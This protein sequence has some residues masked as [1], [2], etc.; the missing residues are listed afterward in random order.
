MSIDVISSVHERV[1]GA[2]FELQPGAK[3]APSRLDSEAWL[4]WFRHNRARTSAEV[5]EPVVLPRELHDALVHALQVFQL[6]EAGEGRVAKEAARSADPVLDAALVE[7][8]DLYI[9]EEGRHARELLV[10][11]RAM[12]VEPLRRT[13]AEK[14]FRWTRRAMGL[15][16]KML[17]IAVAEIVGVV[18][19]GL[20]RDR[21]A[22]SALADTAARI[23]ADEAAHL[24]FQAAL[25]RAFLA[26][27]PLPVPRMY[28]AAVAAVFA[29]VLAAAIA[30]VAIDQRAFLRAIG[31]SPT[32]LTRRCVDELRARWPLEDRASTWAAFAKGVGADGTRSAHVD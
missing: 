1:L 26:H 13:T 22:H 30:T 15:R 20:V 6:G 10:V 19:Y 28:A 21:I 31:C 8:V 29:L 17:T 27:P 14:L 25:F 9:R 23:A 4:V 5:P 18:F 16:Q 32:E 7:C 3:V 2:P 11:L 24:D 12:G